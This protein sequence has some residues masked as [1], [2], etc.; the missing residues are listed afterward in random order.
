[1]ANQSIKKQKQ[2]NERIIKNF[3]LFIGVTNLLFLLLS[4]PSILLWGTFTYFNW[5]TWLLCLVVYGALYFVLNSFTKCEFDGTQL[6]SAGMDLASGGLL[7]YLFDV[8][9]VI[10]ATQILSVISNWFWLIALI[11]IFHI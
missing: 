3:L 6:R 1:M 11:V 9:Y 4:L 2:N 7:E 5:I 10:G 8:A